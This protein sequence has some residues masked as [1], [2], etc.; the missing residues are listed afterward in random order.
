MSSDRLVSELRD[1]AAFMADY[2]FGRDDTE[3]APVVIAAADEIDRLL[4][5]VDRL[6]TELST[7][8]HE[9]SDLSYRLAATPAPARTEDRG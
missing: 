5:E 9:N 4:A 1:I 6:T 7:C 3:D 8:D 2:G